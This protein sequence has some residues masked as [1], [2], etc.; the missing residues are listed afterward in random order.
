M[1]AH[2]G[3]TSA[4]RNPPPSRG[5]GGSRGGTQ[6]ARRS[7]TPPP[8]SFSSPLSAPSPLLG[9]IALGEACCRSSP[10][11]PLPTPQQGSQVGLAGW[12]GPTVY[13][14][15]APSPTLH[16]PGPALWEMAVLWLRPSYMP[17]PSQPG[18][19]SRDQHLL[20]PERAPLGCSCRQKRA[21]ASAV[22]SPAPPT[23]LPTFTSVSSQLPSTPREASPQQ[24]P[25][26]RQPSGLEMPLGAGAR[27]SCCGKL[28][29]KRD[30]SYRLL[31]KPTRLHR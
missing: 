9:S 18:W 16:S 3:T 31:I 12:R 26:R 4:S 29:P 5:R 10:P 19:W 30:C 1:E 15:T 8:V 2:P 23:L 24:R 13:L 14:A 7:S 6:Q 11:A 27:S 28:T 20:P 25:P 22:S 17:N 21:P